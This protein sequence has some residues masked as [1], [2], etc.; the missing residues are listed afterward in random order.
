V[1]DSFVGIRSEGGSKRTCDF[2]LEGVAGDLLQLGSDRVEALAFALPDLD[3]QK[4][5]KMPVTV[6]RAGPRPLGTVE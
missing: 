5:E 2:F 4:L 1:R 3:R 6:R